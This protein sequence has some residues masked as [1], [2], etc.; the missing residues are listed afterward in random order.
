MTENVLQQI[1]V[2]IIDS[3]YGNLWILKNIVFNIGTTTH[4]IQ[5]QDLKYKNQFQTLLQN[6]PTA[7]PIYFLNNYGQNNIIIENQCRTSSCL[8]FC[9]NFKNIFEQTKE[10]LTTNFP[11]MFTETVDVSNYIVK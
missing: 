9:L 8:N 1:T 11:G 5:F 4:H 3:E 7:F 2:I 6:N 10:Y